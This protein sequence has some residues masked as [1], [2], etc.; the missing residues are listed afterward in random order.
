[1]AGL[2]PA[3][4]DWEVR[5]IRAR[6]LFLLQCQSLD[7][8]LLAEFLAQAVDGAF[9]QAPELELERTK[10]SQIVLEGG[11]GGDALGLA[12]GTHRPLVEAARK[13]PQ[14]RA[15]RA[16]AAHEFGLIKALE[17]T[18]RAQPVAGEPR[19]GRLADAENLR[20]RPRRQEGGRLGATEHGKAAR[21]V[22]VGRG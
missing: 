15:F 13:P 18:D 17:V 7:H 2:V 14:P 4:T 16:V 12:F 22:E 1:M 21:L 20:H 8:R 3:V 9:G 11:L 19:L 5:D 6:L 10:A